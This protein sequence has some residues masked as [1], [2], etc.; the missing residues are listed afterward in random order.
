[1]SR[2]HVVPIPRLPTEDVHHFR[3]LRDT[4]EMRGALKKFGAGLVLNRP[5]S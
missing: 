3:R 5:S 2:P 4:D 1:V